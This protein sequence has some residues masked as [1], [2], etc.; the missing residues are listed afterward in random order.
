L[1]LLSGKHHKKIPKEG[2]VLQDHHQTEP[3]CTESAEV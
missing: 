3:L 2:Y 1:A